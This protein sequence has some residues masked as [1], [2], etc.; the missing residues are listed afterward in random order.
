MKRHKHS[1]KLQSI[2][3]AVAGGSWHFCLCLLFLHFHQK[4]FA[5]F[6]ALHN[7][8]TVLCSKSA[9]TRALERGGDIR[10]DKSAGMSCCLLCSYLSPH[11][12]ADV[13]VL[14]SI[15]AHQKFYFDCERVD[16]NP[17]GSSPACQGTPACLPLS[18]ACSRSLAGAVWLQHLPDMGTATDTPAAPDQRC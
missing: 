1:E 5:L 3:R 6:L 16:V 13:W 15:P 17:S 11:P 18:A 8:D 7:A 14:L 12:P 2:C 10:Q 9:A 4:V